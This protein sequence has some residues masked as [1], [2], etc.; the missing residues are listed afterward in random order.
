MPDFGRWTSNG[1]DPSLN[2]INRTDRFLDALASEQ[3]VYSTDRG[4]AELAYLLAGWR[5]ERAR[6]RPRQ[7]WR[8][9]A[10]PKQRCGEPSHRASAPGCRWPCSARWPRRC[11]ASAAS[12]AVV[13]GAGPGDALYGLR[14]ML[15]GE[16]Q[17]TRDDAGGAGGAD[18]TRRGAAADR[19]GPVGRPR[20][21]SCRPSPRPSRR[22]T[23]LSAN[24]NWSPVARA[25]RQGR[26]PGCRRDRC[27]PACAAAD[28]CPTVPG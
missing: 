19:P 22:S 25:D 11:C 15:F 1:G 3:P 7:P 23:T 28:A 16:Q 21:T 6:C 5:D 27:R 14:T 24:R 2:E 13:A 18:R 26:G 17:A 4:E 12:A 9:S 20:R 8:R 10:T